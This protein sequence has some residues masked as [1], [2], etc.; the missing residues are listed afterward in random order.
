[1]PGRGTTSGI[2]V[3]R[4]GSAARSPGT[5]KRGAALDGGEDRAPSDDRRVGSVSKGATGAGSPVDAATPTVVFRACASGLILLIVASVATCAAGGTSVG[6]V[7][8]AA[9]G[10][11]SAAG[12]A[13]SGSEAASWRSDAAGS[14]AGGAGATG[15]IAGGA[16]SSGGVNTSATTAICGDAARSTLGAGSITAGAGGS[17]LIDDGA[18][19]GSAS[20]RGSEV[21]GVCAKGAKGATS[22][23][24]SDTTCSRRFH[25]R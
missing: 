17:T 8:A 24:G 3:P 14:T 16:P 22:Q 1:M 21:G 25:R 15:S 19:T 12:A 10:I 20:G 6:G 7:E 9:I 13:G 23:R 4:P 5:A 2:R 18:A 11:D